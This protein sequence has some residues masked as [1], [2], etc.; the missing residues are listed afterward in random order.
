LTLNFNQYGGHQGNPHLQSSQQK[1]GYVSDTAG[2]WDSQTLKDC[3]Q[4]DAQRSRPSEKQEQTSYL[5]MSNNKLNRKESGGAHLSKGFIHF[6][7]AT[8]DDGI[9]LSKP[10]GGAHN[11]LS[12]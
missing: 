4:I 10:T 1:H 9:A 2:M 5:E 11:T 3:F 8:K 6:N 12:R 7:S